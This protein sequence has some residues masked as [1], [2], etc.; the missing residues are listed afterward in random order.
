MWLFESKGNTSGLNRAWVVHC[1]LVC[2]QIETNHVVCQ[3]CFQSKWQTVTLHTSPDLLHFVHT[4]LYDKFVSRVAELSYT[5]KRVFQ[6]LVLP[7]V[8]QTIIY[9]KFVFQSN[10]VLKDWAALSFLFVSRSNKLCFGSNLFPEWT[11]FKRRVSRLTCLSVLVWFTDR[12]NHIVW[13]VCFQSD[14]TIVH[15]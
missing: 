13:Q 8:E 9:G 5:C 4:I 1:T 11:N 2:F 3:V 12:T 10:R 7:K 15:L 14:R 6:L